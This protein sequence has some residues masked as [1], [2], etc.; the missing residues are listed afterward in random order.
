MKVLPI[1]KHHEDLLLKYGL[2]HKK[3]NRCELHVFNPGET[4]WAEEDE[5]SSLLLVLNGKAKICSSDAN[6]NNLILSYYISSGFIGDIEFIMNHLEATA[7]VIAVSPFECISL[8]YTS[9]RDQLLENNAFMNSLALDLSEKL[10]ECTNSY[11][12]NVLKTGEQRLCSYLLQAEYK[13]FFY[14]NYQDVSA[15]IGLSYRHLLRLLKQLNEKGI[16]KREKDGYQIMKRD[17]LQHIACET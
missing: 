3:L 11:V 4:I 8:P 15:T 13:G 7:S 16:I 2:N 17:Q 10:F 14:D 5:L 6:G 1:K 9:N 12:S